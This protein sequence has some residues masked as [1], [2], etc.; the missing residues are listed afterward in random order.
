MTGT[1]KCLCIASDVSKKSRGGISENINRR[2]AGKEEDPGGRSV[3]GVR[4]IH[5]VMGLDK[6]KG[7]QPR[8]KDI[9]AQSKQRH[10]NQE[11]G[12]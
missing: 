6:K 1:D 10:R 12:K 2:V 9:A 11:L 8:R 7:G 5:E 4:R 3:G